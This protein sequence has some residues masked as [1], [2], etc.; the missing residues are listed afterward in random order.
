MQHSDNAVTTGHAIIFASRMDSWNSST[1]VTFVTI[2][3]IQHTPVAKDDS[4]QTPVLNLSAE[5]RSMGYQGLCLP[6]TTE[7]WK[8]RWEET[9]LLPV[10][11]TEKD[12]VSEKLAEEWRSKPAFIEDEVT[13]ARIGM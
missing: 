6:L 12:L 7:N 4:V 2:D 5:A 9:C 11:S 1:I 8:A 3:D 10:G 13:M